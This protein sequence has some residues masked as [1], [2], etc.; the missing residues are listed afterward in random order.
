M[1][2]EALSLNLEFRQTVLGKERKKIAQLVHRKLLL[3]RRAA[4]LVLLVATASAI[5]SVALRCA[6]SCCALRLPGS[7][8]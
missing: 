7:L 5:T 1:N 4:R 6:S 3:L 8:L 2:A